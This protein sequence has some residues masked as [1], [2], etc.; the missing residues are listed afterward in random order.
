MPS[1]GVMLR[2]RRPEPSSVRCIA[3]LKGP[4]PPVTPLLKLAE[5]PEPAAPVPTTLGG[6]L[7]QLATDFVDALGLGDLRDATADL[8]DHLG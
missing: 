5:E 6:K 7:S 8:V 2:L 4:I 3:D 1:L